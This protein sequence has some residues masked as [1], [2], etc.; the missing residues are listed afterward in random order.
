MSQE[1]HLFDKKSLRTVT[2]KTA[3]LAGRVTL[4]DK[5]LLILPLRAIRGRYP[6]EVAR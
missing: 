2:G 5:T 3:L 1:G 6:G 4:S